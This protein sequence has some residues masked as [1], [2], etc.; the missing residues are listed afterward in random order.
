MEEMTQ[1]SIV[2]YSM[3][4]PVNMGCE[5]WKANY[6]NFIYYGNNI[7]EPEHEWAFCEE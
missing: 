3:S 5:E 4:G 7:Q 1:M 2:Q 6:G